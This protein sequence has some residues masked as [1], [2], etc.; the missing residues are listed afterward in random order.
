MTIDGM[1][2]SV[3]GALI[4]AVLVVGVS[5]PASAVDLMYD[6]VE[7][8]LSELTGSADTSAQAVLVGLASPVRT[9]SD[10]ALETESGGTKVIVASDRS[11]PISMVSSDGGRL[12][13]TLPDGSADGEAEDVTPG[14]VAFDQQDGTHAAVAAKADGTLQLLSVISGPDAPT[15]FVYGLSTD[16]PLKLE[17]LDDG[18]V[19]GYTAA[20]IPVLT[21]ATPWATDAN[22]NSVST[23]FEVVGQDLIQVVNHEAPGVAYPVVADP[24][25]TWYWWGYITKFNRSETRQIANASSDAAALAILCGLIAN[26]PGAVACGLAG[27]IVARVTTNFYRG[28]VARGN[29]V[30]INTVWGTP[31]IPFEVKC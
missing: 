1:A 13:V 27:F 28:V 11:E 19:V 21:V 5:V 2:R 14:V 16:V 9:P 26:L 10:A 20:G 23:S 30:Q 25:L 4:A 15:E 22:G 12:E 3:L 8:A 17:R 24:Q 6:P 18:S 7:N 31:A 29:C